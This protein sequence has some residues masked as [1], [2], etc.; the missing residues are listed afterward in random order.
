[1]LEHGRLDTEKKWRVE[2][3]RKLDNPNEETTEEERFMI[4][5]SLYGTYWYVGIEDKEEDELIEKT[6]RMEEEKRMVRKV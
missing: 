1:M 5:G 3:C 6:T 4:M 2:E